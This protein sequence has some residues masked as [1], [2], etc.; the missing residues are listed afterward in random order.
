MF[1]VLFLYTWWLPGGGS[2]HDVNVHTKMGGVVFFVKPVVNR[3]IW[4][5]GGRW[6]ST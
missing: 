1:F 3:P 5:S 4:S 6:R 2:T